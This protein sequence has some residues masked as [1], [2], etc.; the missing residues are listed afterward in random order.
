[1]DTPSLQK[2]IAPEDSQ[3]AQTIAPGDPEEPLSEAPAA[4]PV[5][6]RPTSDTPE[7]TGYEFISRLGE[8]GMGVV[9]HAVQLSTRREVAVKLLGGAFGSERILAR[10]TREVELSARLSHPNICDV[11]DSG[12]SGTSIIT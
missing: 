3:A 2:T 6:V 1:M 4:A 12:S 5:D 10:F 8:G 7:I 11:Y 9:W